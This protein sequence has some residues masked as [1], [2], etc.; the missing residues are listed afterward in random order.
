MNSLNNPNQYPAKHLQML[1]NMRLIAEMRNVTVSQRLALSFPEEA[2]ALYQHL[3]DM[4]KRNIRIK[5]KFDLII[6]ARCQDSFRDIMWHEEGIF[7]T[8]VVMALAL[9][10]IDQ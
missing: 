8:K 6:E 1:T 7:M 2:L 10:K 3:R 4:W 9:K 5:Y